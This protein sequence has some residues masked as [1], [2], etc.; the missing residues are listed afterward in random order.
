MIRTITTLDSDWRT[1]YVYGGLMMGVCQDYEASDQIF[2][3]GHEKFPDDYYF[4]ASI[5]MNAYSDHKDYGKAA[6][7]MEIASQLE[8]AP[9]WYRRSVAGMLNEKGQRAVAIEYLKQQ[10]ATADSE[11]M[12]R[13]D[14]RKLNRLLH[15]EYAEENCRATEEK[16]QRIRS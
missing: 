4:P 15:E 6:H 16:K 13:R 8:N 9:E 3:M 10:L 1:A 7:W 12:K 14:Q 2:E 11:S 5:A